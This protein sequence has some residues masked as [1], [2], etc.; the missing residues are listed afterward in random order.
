MSSHKWLNQWLIRAETLGPSQLVQI[1][2]PTN[3]PAP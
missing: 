2:L 3:R 1:I